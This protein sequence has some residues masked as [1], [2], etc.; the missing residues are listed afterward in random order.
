MV[1][2]SSMAVYPVFFFSTGVIDF[3]TDRIIRPKYVWNF[4]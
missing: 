3:A 4:S 1:L 2:Q